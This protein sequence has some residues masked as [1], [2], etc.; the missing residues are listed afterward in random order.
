M[1]ICST[2]A[3]DMVLVVVNYYY[4]PETIFYLGPGSRSHYFKKSNV[5]N[6][7]KSYLTIQPH[8]VIYTVQPV[9]CLTHK[10]ENIPGL[11]IVFTF[12]YNLKC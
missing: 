6:L 11:S 12:T 10:H 5:F 2:Y 1:N 7:L 9:F 4:A 3:L 8:I